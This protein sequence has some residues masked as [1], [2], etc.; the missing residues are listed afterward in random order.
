MYRRA[1]GE[2][3]QDYSEKNQGA[4]G[5]K[6]ALSDAEMHHKG[7]GTSQRD[8]GTGVE[9]QSRETGTGTQGELWIR[10]SWPVTEAVRRIGGEKTPNK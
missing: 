6:C 8:V 2:N 1:R 4:D 7:R 9:N 10:E 5:G 3:S